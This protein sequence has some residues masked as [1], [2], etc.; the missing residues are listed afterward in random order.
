[1]VSGTFLNLVRGQT[2]RVVWPD[3]YNKHLASVGYLGEFVRMEK[4][5]D[6]LHGE[7]LWHEAVFQKIKELSGR[8]SYI[9]HVCVNDN[10]TIKEESQP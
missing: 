6:S 10:V 8:R 2:Y 4:K 3:H 5:Y 7:F 9:F 1:M